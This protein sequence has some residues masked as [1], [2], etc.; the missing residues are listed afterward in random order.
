MSWYK[1][2]T[3]IPGRP[4]GSKN[5][6]GALGQAA[7]NRRVYHKLRQELLAA[8]GNKCNKC[9][10]AD[11]RALQLDHVAG[12]GNKHLMAARAAHQ[13]YRQIRQ[14]GFPPDYQILCANCNWI[15]RHEN[16][17]GPGTKGWRVL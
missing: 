14:Q 9:G 10:F 7:V 6:K 8:Y 5:K 1:G 2:D 12:G 4:P 17:E 3:L 15:K 13:M 11:P 16:G